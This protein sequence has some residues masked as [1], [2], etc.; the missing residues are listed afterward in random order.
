MTAKLPGGTT[1]AEKLRE[2]E[3]AVEEAKR[4]R[5]GHSQYGPS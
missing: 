5:V 3:S 4:K 1:A 2:L